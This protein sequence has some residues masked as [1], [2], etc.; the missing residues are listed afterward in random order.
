MD[1]ATFYN[2][3]VA[4]RIGYGNT[5]CKS[6]GGIGVQVYGSTATWHGG[7]GWSAMTQDVCDHCW[8]SG[9]NNRPWPSHRR[10]EQM[11]RRYDELIEIE[12][13]YKGLLK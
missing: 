6:C 12:A 1:R 8:G 3:I 7:V 2:N 13:M 9:D 5:P 11:A 10:Y 4:D